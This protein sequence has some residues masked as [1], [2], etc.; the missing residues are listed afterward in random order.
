MSPSDSATATAADD[1]DAANATPAVK[2]LSITSRRMED[3]REPDKRPLDLRLITRLIGYMRPYAARR[4]ALFLCVLLR[5]IQ[6]PL[7]GWSI[8]AIIRGPIKNH[9]KLAYPVETIVL[10]ALGVLALT[11]FTQLVLHFRQRLALELGEAVLHDLRREIFA[12]LQAMPMSFY[13][14]TKIGRIISRVTSDCEAL[15]VGVQDVLFV[16][17]VG[18]IQMSV[19]ALIM[20]YYDWALFSIVVAMGPIIYFLN[21]YF[22][23]RLSTAYRIMQ[24]GFSRLTSTLAE[25]INGVRLTQAFVREETNSRL[26]KDL[27]DWHGQNVVRAVRME[28]MLLPLLEMSS[29]SFIV[30]LILVGG[31]RVLAPGI[32]M[33][34]ENLITFFFLANI[35][36]SPI[37][38]L[39]TQYNQA[40]TAMA[41]A[42]RVFAL[43]DRPP[44]WQDAPDAVPLPPMEGRVELKNVTFGYDLDRP[45]LH[46]ISL[47]AEPGRNIALVGRTGSGKSSIVNLITRFYLP[48]SG[49]VLIDGYDTRQITGDSL[50]HQMGL[51]LQQNFLF[52]GT[53]L[54]NIRVGRPDATDE[55][56]IQSARDLD[57]LDLLQSLPRG[58]QTQ[59]G[60][61]G[62]QL[63]LGQRQ[64]V[65]FCRAMLAR[66]R[67]VILDEA[68]SSVDTLTE[69]RIQ[70]ALAKLLAGRTSFIVAHRLSTIRHADQVLVLEDGRILERGTHE[71]LMT[72]G[73]LYASLVRQFIRG[74]AA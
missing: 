51:V 7:I 53:I 68:T 72:H 47:L 43:L 56:A 44:E 30:A 32:Q 45:V 18:A 61:R 5:G 9:D 29:Q 21:L 12:H 64:L 37:Q 71:E 38:I 24:E 73:G 34:P 31:Y 1:A 15:R 6:L 60:E 63:S 74:S 48:Q 10:C 70:R 41:G 55:E 26:F 40:L 65:C 22:R 46:D 28:G 13:N 54:E 52:T 36:F 66:P 16:T 23:G 25:S 42:E 27:L 50:H 8:G 19:S 49:A 35:F 14:K 67:I 59:V 11:G 3:D 62:A 4:N 2:K 20:L 69:V 58:L 57:C 39:G 33:S 17:L